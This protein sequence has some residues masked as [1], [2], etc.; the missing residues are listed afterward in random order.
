MKIEKFFFF[1]IKGSEVYLSSPKESNYGPIPIGHPFP[2]FVKSTYFGSLKE[3]R[4]HPRKT[5]YFT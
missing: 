4:I 1:I 3:K 5:F 2:S